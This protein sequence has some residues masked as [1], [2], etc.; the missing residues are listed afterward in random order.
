[1]NGFEFPASAPKRCIVDSVQVH[2][3]DAWTT[4]VLCLTSNWLSSDDWPVFALV[5]SRLTL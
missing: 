3:F 2:W 5:C 1:M 4:F